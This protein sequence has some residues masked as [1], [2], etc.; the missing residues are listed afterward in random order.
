[1]TTKAAWL[2]YVNAIPKERSGI[3]IDVP[4]HV[5]VQWHDERGRVHSRCLPL[6]DADVARFAKLPDAAADAASREA[7]LRVALEDLLRAD[8]LTPT[9]ND[10]RAALLRDKARLA[11]EPGRWDV[12]DIM[13]VLDELGLFAILDA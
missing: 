7:K 11:H 5:K 8:G 13:A 2:V 4:A 10:V 6:D 9:L 3:G 12:A 1:M